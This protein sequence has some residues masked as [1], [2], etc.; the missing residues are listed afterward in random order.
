MSESGD[1][2]LTTMK[3]ADLKRELKTRSLAVSGNKTELLERLQLAL[4]SSDMTSDDILADDPEDLQAEDL[5]GASDATPAGGDEGTKKKVP[6]KRDNEV[7]PHGSNDAEKEKENVELGSPAAKKAHVPITAEK[8][9]SSTEES[10]EPDATTEASAGT[11]VKSAAD[12]DKAKARADRFG[13]KDL[14][15]DSKKQERAD[16]F[17]LPATTG[18]KSPATKLGEAPSADLGTL[19]K[20]AERFGQSTSTSLKQMEMD[21][22]I[23][24]RQ[25]RFGV[26]EPTK[27]EAKAKVIFNTSVNSVVLD[28]KMKKRAE[29]FGMAAS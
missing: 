16:R 22:K 12:L 10:T 9:P 28:E 21:E 8:E 1:L 20:R 24:K 17:G 14:S 25:E 15:S 11:E 3:V 13:V 27:K 5:E 19:K 23:K 29:R 6:I 18:D 26:V 7:T 4:M 2:D